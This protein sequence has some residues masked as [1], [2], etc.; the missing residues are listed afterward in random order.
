MLIVLCLS[1]VLQAGAQ[2]IA[3]SDMQ[4]LKQTEDSLAVLCK[5]MIRDDNPSK[6]FEA[7]SLFTRTLVRA[8][9][10]P[11]SFWYNFD[12]VITVSQLYAPDSSF[13]I[14]TWQYQKDE[15]YF[16]QRGAIQMNT[17][18]GSLK[19]IPLLDGSDFTATPT[20]S[21]RTGRNWIGAIYYGEIL[22]NTYNNQKYYTLF[23]YDDNNISSTKKW[24]EV[25]HFDEAGN[26]QFGGRFFDY[27]DDSLKAPQP[28]YRFCLEYK[29]DGRARMVYDAE[30]NMIIFDHLVS[31]ANDQSKKFTLIPDGDYE[32]FKWTNGKWVH[33]NK[34]FDQQL[35]DGQAPMPEPLKDDA[36]N[37]NEQK[38]QQQSEKNRAKKKPKGQGF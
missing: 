36:G 14:F 33:V 6:R 27:K 31:E 1:S 5:K 22:E 15:D 2:K 32:G 28:A 11:N 26:P 20:D 29:K 12:S 4:L 24:L 19:L 21:I 8:L 7:D 9:R 10:I 16:R 17:Q 25:L 34:I 13:R 3:G 18:D 23:G 37:N 35:E 38:L 30:M